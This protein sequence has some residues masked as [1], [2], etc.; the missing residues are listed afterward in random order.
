M[1]LEGCA[2]EMLASIFKLKRLLDGTPQRQPY[3]GTFLVPV[4]APDAQPG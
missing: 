2:E 3:F 1:L 4:K